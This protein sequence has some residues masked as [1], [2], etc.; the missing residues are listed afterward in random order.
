MTL[1]IR[2]QLCWLRIK[3]RGLRRER[4]RLNAERAG[5]D[6]ALRRNARDAEDTDVALAAAE[7]ALAAARLAR[8]FP[9]RA[10][11]PAARAGDPR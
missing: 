6:W 2:L 9:L 5:L 1:L 10:Q 11:A 3:R 7:R 8:R 4:G